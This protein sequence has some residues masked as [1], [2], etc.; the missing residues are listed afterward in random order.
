M[1]IVCWKCHRSITPLERRERDKKARRTWLI[2][3]C[4]YERCGANLD[5]VPAPE[6]RLWNGSFFE[7]PEEHGA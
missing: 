5:I 3:Y 6:V 7:D 1:Y 4:P 2:T